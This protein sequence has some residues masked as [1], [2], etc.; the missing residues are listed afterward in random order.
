MKRLFFALWPDQATH[1]HCQQIT[2]A[3]RDHGKPVAA[4]NLH[5]TLVF[6]GQV[7][8][9]KQTAISKAADNIQ[10]EAMNLRFNRLSY[11]KKPAVVCLCAEQTDPAVQQLVDQL[12]NAARQN[13][14]MIDDRPFKPHVTLL[15]KA[16]SQPQHL[17]ESIQWQADGFCLV[18]SCS[19]P[20]GVEY[21]VIQRWNIPK[22]PIKLNE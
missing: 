9:A 3:L 12:A 17:F 2:Q 14:L 22:M 15:R 6:L 10:F 8:A 1:Q 21:R 7:D 19:T 5:V 11:W 16:R 13:G 18:E 4:M 20:S